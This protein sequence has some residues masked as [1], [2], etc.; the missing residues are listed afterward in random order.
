M[1]LTPL[2]YVQGWYTGQMEAEIA[3]IGAALISVKGGGK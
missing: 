2:L 3:Q 1:R